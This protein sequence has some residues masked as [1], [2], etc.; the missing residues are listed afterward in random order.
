VGVALGRGTDTRSAVEKAIKKAEKNARKIQVVGDTIPHEI[1]Q[2]KGAAK[3]MLRP[4]RPGT[5]VIAGSSVRTVLEMCGVDNVYGKIMGSSDLVANAYCT[6]EA[7]TELRSKRV[8][9]RMHNMKDRLNLKEQLDKERKARE[10]LLRKKNK[11]QDKGEGKGNRRGGGR[12]GGGN[13]GRGD[14]S[15]RNSGPRAETKE[16]KVE[17]PV[18]KPAPAEKPVEKPTTAEKPVEPT[19][20]VKNTGSTSESKSE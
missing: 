7:L 4:A 6:F 20:E 15:R 13:R 8:L 1:V 10:E 14:N 18:E 2:K 12:K 3:V 9:E 5:G 11:E 17:K 16:V 19:S